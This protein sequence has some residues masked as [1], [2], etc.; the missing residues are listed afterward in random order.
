VDVPQVTTATEPAKG[1]PRIPLQGTSVV[2]EH[3]GHRHV[4]NVLG[5]RGLTSRAAAVTQ[6]PGSTSS[7]PTPSVHLTRM[8][9]TGHLSSRS[10]HGP[11]RG[12]C[13]LPPPFEW[14]VQVQR[15]TREGEGDGAAKKSEVLGGGRERHHSLPGRGS[16]PGIGK[17]LIE[18]GRGE[19]PR[20]PERL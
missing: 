10:Q 19:S 4:A 3:T 18:H 11:N 16:G 5:K 7:E 8:A 14:S 13:I 17:A 9:R 2:S 6:A 12:S 15:G 20:L 1:R